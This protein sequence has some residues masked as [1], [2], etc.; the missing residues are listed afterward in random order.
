MVVRIYA[1]A[2]ALIRSVEGDDHA[3]SLLNCVFAADGS[4][5]VSSELTLAEVLVG[6][7]KLQR[8]DPADRRARAWRAS[9][10]A[11]FDKAGVLESAAVSASVL[12]DAAKLR[13]EHVSL[14]LPDAIHLTTAIAR[15]CDVMLSHDKDLLRAS[16]S[17]TH[18][19]W[20]A[21][22]DLDALLA[23]IEAP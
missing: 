12:K 13:A 16:A 9:Y 1:D 19:T 14:K 22:R 17:H 23:R 4:V 11:L 8:Q 2:N 21:D 15:G 3:A 7:M 6:P 5:I 10:E 18:A 20:L